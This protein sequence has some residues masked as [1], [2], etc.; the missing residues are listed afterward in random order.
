[1]AQYRARV[2]M[3]TNHDTVVM[4]T[5][6][7]AQATRSTFEKHQEPWQLKTTWYVMCTYTRDQT[8]FMKKRKKNKTNEH[9]KNNAKIRE[10]DSDDANNDDDDKHMTVF[11]TLN[12]D[13]FIQVSK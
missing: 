5:F 8:E 4:E 10:T 1:M 6:A 13:Q 2:T 11:D 3:T 9:K 7:A 12:K